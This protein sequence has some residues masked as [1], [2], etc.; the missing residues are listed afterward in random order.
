MRCLDETLLLFRCV[1]FGVFLQVAVFARLGNCLHDS[2]PILRFQFL[3]FRLQQLVAAHGHWHLAH[4]HYLVMQILQAVDV[5][6]IDIFDG[7]AGRYRRAQRRVVGDVAAYRLGANRFRF[8]D[9]PACLP[10]C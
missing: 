2:W 8:V 1:V 5:M 4:C 7:T 3:E 6:I 10:S 9:R